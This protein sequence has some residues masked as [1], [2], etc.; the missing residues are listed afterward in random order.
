[1]QCPP[2]SFPQ[3]QAEAHYKGHKHARRLKA[4]EA[5]KSKQKAV[6]A[7][8]RDSTADFTP[9]LEGGEDPSGAG[10]GRAAVQPQCCAMTCCS[11]WCSRNPTHLGQHCVPEL[12]S[13]VSCRAQGG[14]GMCECVTG[15]LPPRGH[16]LAADRG[17]CWLVHALLSDL[18]LKCGFG[19]KLFCVCLLL[20]VGMGM[21]GRGCTQL[22]TCSTARCGR[23]ALSPCLGNVGGIRPCC[24]PC[25][26]R[27]CLQLPP[28]SALELSP[29]LVFLGDV[30]KHK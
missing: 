13:A 15:L 5:M 16:S 30:Y 18:Q 11:W 7:V 9:S 17:Q 28:C 24:R 21:L 10:M 6:G 23:S 29:C 8:G 14:T 22:C 2:L 27:P 4:I 19:F 26:T 25:S 1:M 20:G 12:P 3:N